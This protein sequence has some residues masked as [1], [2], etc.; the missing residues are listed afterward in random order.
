MVESRVIV[1]PVQDK[2]SLKIPLEVNFGLPD[3]EVTP[4]FVRLF[5][6]AVIQSGEESSRAL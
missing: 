2:L 5:H 4:N 3:S 1:N 6:L